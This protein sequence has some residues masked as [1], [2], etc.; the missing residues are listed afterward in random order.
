MSAEQIQYASSGYSN[1]L[2]FDPSA[3]VLTINEFGVAGTFTLDIGSANDN[4][5]SVKALGSGWGG[6][7][8]AEI[9]T[10]RNSPG[11]DCLLSVGSAHAPNTLY[12]QASAAVGINNNSPVAPLDVIG[13]FGAS[14]P[15]QIRVSDTGFATEAGFASDGNGFF[16]VVG[17]D[18]GALGYGS[19]ASGSFTEVLRVNNSGNVGIATMSPGATL[20]V[21]GQARFYTS[22]GGNNN[23]KINASFQDPSL[24]GVTI[25]YNQTYNGVPMTNA[26]YVQAESEGVAYR[27]LLLEPLGGMVGIGTSAPSH[28][29]NVN[30]TANIS[31]NLTAMIQSSMASSVARHLV[32]KIME[33]PSVHD[34]GCVGDGYT[35][36]LSSFQSA[37]SAVAAGGAG[38][39]SIPAGTT[40]YIPGSVSIPSG[41]RLIGD[42]SPRS[43]VRFVP[44]R[45]PLGYAV[46]VGMSCLDSQ[47]PPHIQTVITP[48]VTAGM[49]PSWAGGV[50]TES[51]GVQWRDEGVAQGAHRFLPDPGG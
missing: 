19:A 46:S 45:W 21:F 23:V 39:L 1:D 43:Q 24:S 18:G 36:D 12:V 16:R 27:N 8:L 34:F 51:T 49:E 29:L 31:G 14:T 6:G 7:L 30:G 41:L 28:T 48:G 15:F 11:T 2:T 22:S 17:T 50:T 40:L 32:P 38:W 26:G 13:P 10:E 33:A 5:L 37:V 42:G 44:N 25:G 4:L 20:N 9:Y 47:S 3:N 35:N